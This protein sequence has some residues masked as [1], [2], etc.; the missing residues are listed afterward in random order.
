M[1]SISPKC[2]FDIQEELEI[3]AKFFQSNVLFYVI[4]IKIVLS[5]SPP[6]FKISSHAIHMSLYF[7]F[8]YFFYG[9]KLLFSSRMKHFAKVCRCPRDPTVKKVRQTKY[10]AS[11]RQAFLMTSQPHQI[12]SGHECNCKVDIITINIEME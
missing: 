7:T 5:K 9:K 1:Y 11:L 10:I 8:S 4:V 12:V 2:I 6:Q 3:Q